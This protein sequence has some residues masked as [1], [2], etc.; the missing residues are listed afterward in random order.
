MEKIGK[1]IKLTLFLLLLF[2]IMPRN[3]HAYLDPGTGSYII[4]ILVAGILGASFTV[5]LYW[6][7]IKS[8]FTRDKK[9]DDASESSG[10]E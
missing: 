6:K 7:K 1:S 9:I 2:S 3:A 4:Q 5:R 8:L 10:E